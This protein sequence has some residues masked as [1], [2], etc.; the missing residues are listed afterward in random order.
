MD[1]AKELAKGHSKVIT[2]KIV[3]YV[4]NNKTRFKVLV[5][6]FFQGPYRTTQR[7]A[8]PL[9]ITAVSHP[10]LIRP[11]L[12]KLLR[13]IQKED[14]HDAV[15]R[16]GFRILQFADI[17]KRMY[18]DVIDLCFRTLQN[19][20][21]AIAIRVFAMTTLSRVIREYPELQNELKIIIEDELPYAKPAFRSRGLRTLKELAARPESVN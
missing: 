1:I 17:P 11:Y 9:G 4:G 2:S 6:L 13:F 7:A 3:D 18:A 5:D 12:A 15:K 21:E 14:A 19:P 16:N 8:W 10:V 20:A